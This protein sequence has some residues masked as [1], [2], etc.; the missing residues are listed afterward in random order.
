MESIW[1]ADVEIRKREA[2]PGEMRVPVVVIGAGLAGILTAYYLKQAGIRAVVLEADRIGSGQTG[3]T[4]A[5]ITSQ[6]N[7][8]YDRL[9][10]TFGHEM[11]GQYARANESAIGEY[12][13]LI[14]EKEIDC[15]F[16]GCPACLYSRTEEALLRREAEAAESLGIKASFGTDSELPFSVAG[17]VRFEN[18]A[19]FHPLKFLAAMAEEVEVYEQTKVLKAEGM[20]VET[21]RG[22]VEA[23]HIVFAA[24]FPFHNV[25]GYYFARMYQERS[26]VEALAGAETLEGM[27]LGIDR[28]GLSFRSQGDLLLLGGGS[29]RTGVNKR[30]RKGP[31]DG[32][33]SAEAWG[34]GGWEGSHRTGMNK[35]GRKGTGDGAGSA[36]ACGEGRYGMLL[37]RAREFYPECREA[38]RWSAQ[39]CMTLDGIPYIGRF[40]RRKPDWY[41]ATG[42]GKWGMTTAMV[43]ARLL[44]ALIS[45]KECPE[46]DIFSPER[47]FTARAAKELAVHGAYTVKGLSKHLLP[48]GRGK[49]IPNCPHMGC[50]LEWNPDEESYDCPCHG[51][52]FDRE[53]HLLDGPAQT[54]CK[55]RE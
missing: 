27:Y 54:D 17:V 55:R 2:L 39:D 22:C 23:E 26:Y 36:E 47:R 50:R 25:P 37:N 6:H 30:G 43:S 44:T 51:S 3:N 18:Q 45:G 20:R 16:L 14:R 46:A 10:R 29:H 42:F 40:S 28:E 48:S 9:I 4:T 11:A 41:V 35:R 15:D 31:G 49:V 34:E 12:E 52:R 1:R 33:G 21:A 53:G 19:R 5:K 7:L 13:R 32:A 24:H 38:A 8:L